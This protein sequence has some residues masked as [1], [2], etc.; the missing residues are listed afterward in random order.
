MASTNAA[1]TRARVAARLSVSAPD[2]AS[3]IIASETAAG[4]GRKRGPAS[5]EPTCQ[6]MTSARIETTRQIMRRLPAGACGV[7]GSGGQLGRLTDELLPPE[8]GEHCVELAR[9]GLL[10]LYRATRY[11][12]RIAFPVDGERPL[13]RQVQSRPDHLPFLGGLGQQIL[14]LARRRQ[15]PVK[16]G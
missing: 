9:V 11:A 8:L 7:E 1:A 6:R 13:V 16:S 3:L 4:E 10:G 5:D 2:R 15:E 14:G 12:L